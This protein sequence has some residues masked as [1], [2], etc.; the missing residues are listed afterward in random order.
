[1]CSHQL[2]F[3]WQN[4]VAWIFLAIVQYSKYRCNFLSST[5]IAHFFEYFMYEACFKLQWVW[6]INFS[7]YFAVASLQYTKFCF[8]SYELLL[9]LHHVKYYLFFNVV[10]FAKILLSYLYLT[11]TSA[12]CKEWL[13]KEFSFD[14]KLTGWI[15][16]IK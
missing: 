6:L 15:T 2:D 12:G 7:I 3:C 14:K 10:I 16:C 1:M 5:F 4:L 11:W 9:D 8:I 13:S